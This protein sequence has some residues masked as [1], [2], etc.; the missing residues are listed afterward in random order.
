MED[1]YS[2]Q[3]LPTK[4]TWQT[5][6]YLNK[7]W[8]YLAWGVGVYGGLV[9][10]GYMFPAKSAKRAAAKVRIA[11]IAGFAS[12][13]AGR[14]FFLFFLRVANRRL[15]SRGPSR[16]RLLRRKRLRRRQPH[17]CDRRCAPVLFV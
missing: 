8:H 15:T 16:E 2:S 14:V 6:P 10:I 11:H 4:R 13:V 7:P 3:G 12:Q 9:L 17:R 1:D 5:I